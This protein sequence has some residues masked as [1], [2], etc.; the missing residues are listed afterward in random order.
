MTNTPPAWTSLEKRGI[1]LD[2]GAPDDWDGGMVECPV[3]WFDEQ[4]G[5]FGMVY[6]GYRLRAESIGKT[7]GYTSVTDPQIGLAWSKDLLHWEKDARAPIFGAS[8][9][10]QS[11]DS[12]GASGPFLLPP[13]V[14]GRS[15]YLLFYFGVTGTGYE[16]GRKTLNVATS[17]DLV[18]WSRYEHN[19][20]ITPSGDSIP[21]RWRSEAI[22]HPNVIR[23]GESFYCF[24]NASGEVDGYHEE[25]I[26]YAVSDDLFNWNVK[27][28]D[29]PIVSGSRVQGAWDSAGRAGDPCVFESDG[30]WWMAFYAWDGTS[31]QD[32]LM[33]TSKEAFPLGWHPFAENPVVRLG[34]SGSYDE[35]HAA[36]PFIVRNDTTHFHFYTAVDGN[37]G[38]R[39]AVATAPLG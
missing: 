3:I 6:T 1:I 14:S 30:Q 22:W 23:V 16:G 19:P 21:N 17:T 9:V 13:S 25:R 24:F 32:G 33:F 4:R 36:K 15:E 8:G 5:E 27:D 18:N 28:D 31:S 38:R 26:G 7:F 2:T 37:Q 11:P 12:H 10:E 34:P 35:L 39:I 29:C 20:V